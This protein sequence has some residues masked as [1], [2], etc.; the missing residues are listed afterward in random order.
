MTLKAQ[1]ASDVSAVFLNEDEF[2]ESW[3]QWPEGDEESALTVVVV[4][5]YPIEFEDP[6]AKRVTTRGE[7]QVTR[8]E[9]YVS[10]DVT[11]S[12]KDVWFDEND[13]K[14]QTLEV[15]P[16]DGSMRRITIQRNDKDHTSRPGAGHLL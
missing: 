9:I 14:Y 2:A 11:V 1:I 15:G 4:P 3:T 5:D 7:E 13:V 12:A 10:G 16:I 6:G 8:F